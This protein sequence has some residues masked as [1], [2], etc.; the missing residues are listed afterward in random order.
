MRAPA[1]ALLFP[2]LLTACVGRIFDAEPAT[3]PGPPPEKSPPPSASPTPSASP[4]DPCAVASSS[5]S[6]PLQ[7]IDR[8]QF[9]RIV[10]Q[11]FPG[12]SV[13]SAFPAPGKGAIYATSSD[14]NAVTSVEAEPVLDA[15][16]EV[17]IAAADR[18][19]S[20]AGLP[21][22][23]A[24]NFLGDFATRAFR[25][26][27]SGEELALLMGVY[28]DAALQPG[29]TNE[30]AIGVAVMAL[31]QMPQFLYAFE[32]LPAPG[33]APRQLSGLEAAQRFALVFTNELPG[34][35]LAGQLEE[36]DPA[37]R[38]AV[39]KGLLSSASGQAVMRGFLLQWL[40]LDGFHSTVHDPA[41]A[42]ALEEELR[43][44]L[45][46]ALASEDVLTTL[47]TS[48]QTQLNSTLQTFY[49]VDVGSTGPSDW[50]SAR[51]PEAQR[52]GVLSH[53]LL[54]AKLGH[55]ADPSYT[56]RGLFVRTM[57]LCDEIR[58]PPPNVMQSMLTGP[59]ATLLQQ[60][61]ARVSA[62][63]CGGCHRQMDPIGYGFGAF[64]GL[65]IY[66]G[67]AAAEGTLSSTLPSI[68]GPFQ[69]LRALGQRLA[70]EPKTRECFARQWLRY[71]LGKTERAGEVCAMKAAA[72]RVAE[73]GARLIDLLSSSAGEA[74]FVQRFPERVP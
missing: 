47:L 6:V 35:D 41:V 68:D 54:M 50:Q 11:L 64:D 3:P 53:P 9:Q 45:D 12:L 22:T 24:Q 55:G 44:D 29:M 19:P 32:L 66:H 67:G 40:G 48:N 70:A 27:A 37:A 17:G 38:T 34:D 26:P 10:A 5:V 15:A 36:A 71:A 42:A 69:G 65:G 72:H 25:R 16:M 18:L 43:R 20:C 57:L 21:A 7:R 33:E 31:L 28:A 56:K 59:E 4:V 60:S 13:S 8:T 23:C 61:Q 49:G 58:P 51:L 73:K 74:I 62:A 1:Y 52:V 30:E 63:G 39:A 14:F 2:L 46:Q